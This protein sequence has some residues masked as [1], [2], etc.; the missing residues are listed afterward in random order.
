LQDVKKPSD[1]NEIV[2]HLDHVDYPITGRDFVAA[3]SNM[4]HVTTQEKDWVKKN[5]SMDRTYNSPD[6]IRK[7]LRI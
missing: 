7:A 5:L 1:V 6:E 2:D 4:E 3:C